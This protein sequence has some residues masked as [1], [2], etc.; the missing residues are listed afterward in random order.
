MIPEHIF[1]AYDIRGEAATDLASPLVRRIGR[2]LADRL[3][4]GAVA[5]PRIAVHLQ[6]RQAV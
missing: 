6:H 2:S 5:R 4:E 3:P 1:R